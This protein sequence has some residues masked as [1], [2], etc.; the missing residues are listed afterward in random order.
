MVF[1]EEAVVL[2]E[3]VLQSEC[4]HQLVTT[5]GD[6]T[7]VIHAIGD[8]DR[9]ALRYPDRH[10]LR[11]G[12]LDAVFLLVCQDGSGQI[13]EQTFLLYGGTVLVLAGG[14]KRSGA[15]REVDTGIAGV[16]S[17]TQCIPEE[18]IIFLALNLGQHFGIGI[19]K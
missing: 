8:S 15:D 16:V 1:D 6:L 17:A 12:G 18:G 5:Q 4:G 19:H 11:L 13:A 7:K 10:I 3:R 2:Y 9:A 14:G